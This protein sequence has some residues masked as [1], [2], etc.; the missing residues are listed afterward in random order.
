MVSVLAGNGSGGS[1]WLDAAI[2]LQ[3]LFYNPTQLAI[4]PAHQSVWVSDGAVIRK[5][6]L[7]GQNPVTS[8]AGMQSTAAEVTGVGAAARFVAPLGVDFDGADTL[9]VADRDSG[10]IRKIALSTGDAE[11]V[12]GGGSANESTDGVDANATF[13]YPAHLALDAAASTL[14]VADNDTALLRKVVM[15][16]GHATV[17]TVAGKKNVTGSTNGDGTTMALFNGLWGVAF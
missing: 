4:D 12:A 15:A 6:S 2:G 1:G 5:I 13:G 11:L 9:Y 7:A 16:G 8:V 3:A 17:T 10:V 14:Y